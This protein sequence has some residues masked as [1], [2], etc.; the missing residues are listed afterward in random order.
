MGDR[1]HGISLKRGKF[2]I[3]KEAFH[4]AMQARMPQRI[5]R[6]FD[7]LPVGAAPELRSD[8]IFPRLGVNPKAAQRLRP[9]AEA[10]RAYL[11]RFNALFETI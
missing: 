8:L 10:R 4:V 7:L 6:Q 1:R 11:D 2:G 5:D 9:P 3:G